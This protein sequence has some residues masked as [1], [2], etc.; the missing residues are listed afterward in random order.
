M[1]FQLTKPT[2]DD[3]TLLLQLI[4]DLAESEGVKKVHTSLA[5]LQEQLFGAQPAAYP[6]L[7]RSDGAVAGFAIYSWKWGTFTG[8]KDMYVHALFVSAAHR[9]KGVAKQ[10]IAKLAQIAVDAGSARMEW[11]TVRDGPMS[12]AFY[13]SIGSQEASHMAVRRLQG[14]ALHALAH[15]AS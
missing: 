15:C 9:R 14:E 1:T 3:A 8:V 10:A 13:D 7:I 11:L 4:Q 5:S 6:L 2:P 12:S